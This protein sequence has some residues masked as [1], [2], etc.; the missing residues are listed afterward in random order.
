MM[1][2]AFSPL[3]EPPV[4]VRNLQGCGMLGTFCGRRVILALFWRLEITMPAPGSGMFSL[5]S[6]NAGHIK[7]RRPV[8]SSLTQI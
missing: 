4:N 6:S 2:E 8:T 3:F 7:V 1:V 5:L